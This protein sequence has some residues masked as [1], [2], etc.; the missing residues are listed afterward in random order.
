MKSNEI[1]WNALKIYGIKRLRCQPSLA[2]RE[3]PAHSARQIHFNQPFANKINNGSAHAAKRLNDDDDD[4]D[5]D[6]SPTPLGSSRRVRGVPMPH[7][8]G[9]K[10]RAHI[11]SP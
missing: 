2:T 11:E 6:D 9:L 1:S 5:D 10:K 3:L 8:I 7:E 4:D